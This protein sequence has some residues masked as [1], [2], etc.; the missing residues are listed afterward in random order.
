[1]FTCGEPVRFDHDRGW[2]RIDVAVCRRRIAERCVCRSGYSVPQHESLR[3]ILGAFELCRLLRRSEDAQTGGVESIHHA[4][5]E[6]CFGADDGKS[7]AFRLRER[8]QCG[9]VGMRDVADTV[10][11]RRA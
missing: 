4:C 1:A 11:G 6:W 2:L 3:K 9:D 5:S 8:Y 10:A 7:D